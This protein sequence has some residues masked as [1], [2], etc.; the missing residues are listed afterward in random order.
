ML[1]N[2][3]AIHRIT[4]RD[5]NFV[6]PERDDV[7]VPGQLACEFSADESA[8]SVD[9][10]FHRT[11]FCSSLEIR[12]SFTAGHSSSRM[13]KM[14][15]SRMR[16]LGR[17]RCLRR[18]PSCLAPRRKMAVRD[19]SLRTSV[20]NSTRLQCQSSNACVSSNNLLSVLTRV[21]C[22]LLGSQV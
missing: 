19:C 9:Y 3:Y 18:I 17:I 16:P 15:E 10:N 2:D 5:V 12:R 14:T 11:L 22:A 13:L 20:I 1:A 8:R 6:V 7:S 21:R 4:I